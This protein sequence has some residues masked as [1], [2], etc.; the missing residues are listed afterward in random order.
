MI[1]VYIDGGGHSLQTLKDSVGVGE[2]YLNRGQRSL[3]RNQN[4]YFI[5]RDILDLGKLILQTESEN[6][7]P[8]HQRVDESK[9]T[10]KCTDS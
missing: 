3:E 5:I 8:L 1:F 6:S 7:G 2:Y 4:H 10:S 9:Q